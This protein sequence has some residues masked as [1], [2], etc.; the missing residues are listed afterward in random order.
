MKTAIVTGGGTGI[1]LATCQ[2]LIAAVMER[3][4]RQEIPAAVIDNP[5][6]LW[7][8]VANRVQPLAGGAAVASAP[9]PD[10]RYEQILSVFRAVAAADPF[11]PD[12]PSWIRRRCA[13]P[14]CRRL[15]CMPARC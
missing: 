6:L 1:G 3:I 9:E 2:R 5:D 13:R 11:D 4:V 12:T 10:R 15:P 14:R 8:P 7:D